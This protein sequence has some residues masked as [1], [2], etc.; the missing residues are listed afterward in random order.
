[1]EA[2]DDDLRMATILRSLLLLLAVAASAWFVLGVREA[3]DTARATALVTGEAP[4]RPA[5]AQRARSLLDSAGTLNPD[6]TVA[7]TRGVL[8]LDQN[9]N[10]AAERTLESVT[11]R[12]PLNLDAWVQLAFAA[13]R[14]GDRRTFAH[15]VGVVSA[16]HPKLK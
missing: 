1:V 2:I 12:E 7:V 16:L 6:L 14:N 3:R 13:T 10:A 5:Q 8:E 11:R 4:L 9:Q 15:A